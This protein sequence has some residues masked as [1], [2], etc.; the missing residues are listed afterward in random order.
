M[1]YLASAYHN[2]LYEW[3]EQSQ[4]DHPRLE[5]VDSEEKADEGPGA[6]SIV[7]PIQN[8]PEKD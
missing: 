4:G 2:V 7:V 5:K 3:Y 6:L 8:A 1:H